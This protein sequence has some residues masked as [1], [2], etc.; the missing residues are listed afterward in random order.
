MRKLLDGTESQE[1]VKPV[2]LKI[3]TKCPGKWMLAD[4]ET[5][6]VEEKKYRIKDTDT[7]DFWL[8]IIT[9]KSFQTYVEEK[10]RVA[11]AEIMQGGEED[12]FDDIV[13]MNGT[14]NA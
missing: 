1:L 9:S 11:S 7:K 3:K 10:Y 12:L 14:E 4:K 6:E 5:G 2:I 13:T 8:P